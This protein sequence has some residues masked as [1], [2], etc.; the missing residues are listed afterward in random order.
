[1]LTELKREAYEAN[2]ALPGHGLV[3]LNFGN[4]S[5]LDRGKGIFAIKP[6]GVD[7]HILKP[8]QMVLVDLDGKIVEGSH[9]PSSDTPT[10]RILYR[11]LAGAAGV[12][13]THSTHAT[14]FAQAGKPIPAL[15]TTHADYF[16]GPVP[17]SRS[18]AASEIRSEYEVNTGIAILESVKGLRMEENGAALVLWHAPFAWGG[19]VGKAVE[20]AVAL[21]FCAKLALESLRIAPARKPMPE[22]LHKKHFF[23]K[24]GPDAYYGQPK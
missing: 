19:S 17:V 11:G 24:H 4:A 1:M 6:S 21:E 14:A 22:V 12:V 5:A 8:S 10:H 7:Y 3:H 9:R 23:R 20:M 16:E 15:G 18:L 13:H 2:L